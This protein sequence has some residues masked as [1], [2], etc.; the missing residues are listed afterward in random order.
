M[1]LIR[2]MG[3]NVVRLSHYEHAEHFHDLADRAGVVLWAE[4]PLVNGITDIA[5]FTSNARQQLTELIRQNYNHPSILFWGIGNEQRAD[6]TRDQHAADRAEHAGAPGGSR[7]ACRPTRSAAP[8]TRAGCPPTPTSSATTPTT[9]GTTR[10]AP[11]SSSARWADNLHAAK[12]TWKIGVS[13]YGAGAGITQH[14]ANPTRPDPYG[15][16]HPEEWQNLVHESHWKQMKTRRYLWSKLIWNM[17]DFA[18]DSRNEGDTPGRNDKGLV[19]Y[20]RKTQK[21]RV[22]LVQG[23]LDDRAVRLHHVAPLHAAHDADGDGEDL[24]EHG[25]RPPAGERHHHRDVR[26]RRSHLQVD[27]RRAHHRRQH[28]RRDRH[29]R[30]DD[31][32]GH[33]HLDAELGIAQSRRL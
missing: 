8:A 11:P 24:L 28:H 5:A 21:G 1:A 22:L 18:V 12:P 33:R 23:Q 2:E 9:A 3:A 19:T 17:F 32:D 13:E 30:H 10:S 14:A 26:R 4:I 27:Q 25:F 16:P 29:H 15:S 20:D 6:N 7:A 31:G